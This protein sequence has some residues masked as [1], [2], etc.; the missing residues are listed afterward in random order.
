MVWYRKKQTNKQKQNACRL[1]VKNSCQSKSNKY[2]HETK[3]FSLQDAHCINGCFTNMTLLACVSQSDWSLPVQE[4]IFFFF[5][6]QY[7]LG[8]PWVYWA[9]D[10]GF[11]WI[12][13]LTYEQ[14]WCWFLWLPCP[15][16]INRIYYAWIF[17]VI[18]WNRVDNGC[19]WCN[20]SGFNMPT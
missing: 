13:S 15:V 7:A 18:N 9:W 4:S 8:G 2:R 10:L 20:Y 3:L 19:F 12:P 16:I 6:V 5:F 1:C 14:H 11:F 17:Y